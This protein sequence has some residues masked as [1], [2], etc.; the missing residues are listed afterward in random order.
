MDGT[1]KQILSELFAAHREIE[2]LR[3]ALAQAQRACAQVP[4]VPPASG[5]RP[6]EAEAKG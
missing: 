2:R 6:T 3:E 1:L 4:Q 5:A